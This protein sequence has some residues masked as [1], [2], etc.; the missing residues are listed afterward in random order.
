MPRHHAQS[1]VPSV[2]PLNTEEVKFWLRIMEEHAVFIRAALPCDQNDLIGDAKNFQQE[3]KNLRTKVEKVQS[4]K[5]FAEL[6][7]QICCILKEYIRYK[8]LLLSYALTGKLCGGSLYPSFL[9]H[10]TREAEYFMALLAKMG[11]KTLGMVHAL[12]TDFWLRIM[13][14]H[15]E[16]LRQ[17][18]DPSE[19]GLI[20]AVEG[21]AE[22]FGALSVQA[23]AFSSM[24]HCQTG[25]FPVFD[26]FLKDSKMASTRLRDF[27]KCIYDMICSSKML[28][29]APALMV[30]HVRR[31]TD[32]FL[33]VLVMMEKGVVKNFK[34]NEV[35]AAKYS[36]G[37]FY[38]PEIGREFEG[39]G[40]LI[41]YEEIIVDEDDESEIEFDRPPWPKP[42]GE[43][44]TAPSFKKPPVIEDENPVSWAKKTGGFTAGGFKDHAKINKREI[45]TEENLFSPNEEA[46]SEAETPKRPPFISKPNAHHTEVHVCQKSIA[47]NEHEPENPRKLIPPDSGQAKSQKHKNGIRW[48]RQ[49]GRVGTP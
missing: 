38:P 26:R 11:G 33:L 10:V 6:I 31:E 37:E 47:K 24:L 23:R 18:I 21:Y 16:L 35:S 44:K 7:S 20:G 13:S 19:T 42:S 1:A 36:M 29:V 12:E 32:H 41:E 34:H 14:D 48:P 39:F 5:K 45:N 2:S 4:E 40:E 9:D 49:L 8:R 30:D 46:A 43:E 15:T 17:F 3:F 27:E 28:T 22:E 25:Q